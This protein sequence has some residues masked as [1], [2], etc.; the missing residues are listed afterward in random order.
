MLE[1]ELGPVRRGPALLLFLQR[2]PAP[3]HVLAPD[4]SRPPRLRREAGRPA[5]ATS[6]PGP[7][8]RWTGPS[9]WP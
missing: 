8:A 6:S 1:Y 7:T 3:A 5:S 2:R 4:R 9:T